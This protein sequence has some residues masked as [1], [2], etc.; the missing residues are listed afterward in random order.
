MAHRTPARSRAGAAFTLTAG[1]FLA[2]SCSSAGAGSVAKDPTFGVIRLLAQQEAGR[3]VVESPVSIEAALL[4]LAAGAAGETERELR[5]LAGDA[6]PSTLKRLRESGRPGAGDAE[7]STILEFGSCL[8]SSPRLR[9]SSEFA[10]RAQRDFSAVTITSQPAQAPAQLNE[11]IARVTRGLIP[12]ILDEPPDPGGVVLANGMVFLGKWMVPFDPALTAPGPFQEAGGRVR[13]VPMM[14]RAGRFRYTALPG[15]QLIELPYD[16]GR[17]SFRVFLPDEQ[18]G[19]DPWLAGANAAS[20]A[21][22]GASLKETS[23]ELV[24]PRLDLAF[25]SELKPALERLGAMAA[26]RPGIADF[27]RMTAQKVPLAVGRIIH[28]AVVKIDEAGTK[29]AAST[30]VQ[31]PGAAQPPTSFRMVVNRPFFFAIHGPVA[32]DVLFV[33][34]VRTL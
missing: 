18:Q 11:W 8:W 20:W 27:S 2:M 1:V 7:G 24:L 31:M 34:L 22:A 5:A 29:A 30:T 23:G 12:S 4:L 33:G 17:F 9:F 16:D 3:T 21:A 32:A 28:R 14:T 25:S 10:R 15:G 19:L 6:V 26:F 13:T